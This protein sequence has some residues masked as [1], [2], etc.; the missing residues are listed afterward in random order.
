MGY[1]PK[2]QLA[3]RIVAR[4]RANEVANQLYAEIIGIFRPLVGQK[5]VK[6]DG[7][8]LGKIKD[9]LPKWD[10]PDD[11]FPKPT[12]M[13]YKG[14]STY[15]LS[16]TV[17]T[18]AQVIGEGCC[19]YEECTVYVCDLDGQNVGERIYDPPNA[20]TDFTADEVNR[21]REEYKTKKKAADE[22]HSA[23]HPF[24]EIDR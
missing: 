16:F 19:T 21:L 9:Q 15:T 20:R 4:N 5:I 14:S 6:V 8:L 22:A 7:S 11:K 17:K 24:G 13:V 3:A 23:L 18:C 10:F 1:N 2:A 12:V